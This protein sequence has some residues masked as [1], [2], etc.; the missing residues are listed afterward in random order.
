[1]QATGLS[2]GRRSQ[3]LARELA[4]RANRAHRRR[5]SGDNIATAVIGP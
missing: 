1:M 5:R 2:S 4:E 3:W